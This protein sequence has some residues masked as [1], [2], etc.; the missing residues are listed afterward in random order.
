M[1]TNEELQLYK[2]LG[3]GRLRNRLHFDG[4]Q[5]FDSPA[6]ILILGP[7]KCELTVRPKAIDMALGLGSTLLDIVKSKQPIFA[8]HLIVDYRRN[9]CAGC[10]Y[11]KGNRCSA[12]ACFTDAKTKLTIAKC[13]KGKW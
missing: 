2:Q 8:D 7:N 9:V 12:C 1:I 10:K 11:Q 3:Y 13:P 6:Y 5:R 4:E